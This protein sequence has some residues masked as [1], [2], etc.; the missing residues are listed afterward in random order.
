MSAPVESRH[1]TRPPL[2]DVEEQLRAGAPLDHPLFPVVWTA[3]AGRR[4]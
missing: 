3:P 1:R 4:P 2:N